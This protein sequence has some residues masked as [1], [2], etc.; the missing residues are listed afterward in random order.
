MKV[1]M[2]VF[3]LLNRLLRISGELQ[4]Y[5]SLPE[6]YWV[7]RGENVIGKDIATGNSVAV[8]SRQAETYLAVASAILERSVTRVADLGCNVAVLADF[9]QEGTEYDGCEYNP[10]ALRVAQSRTAMKRIQKRRFVCANI[11]ALPFASGSY[12]CVVIKDVLEHMEDFR[13]FLAEAARVSYRYVIV[14]NFIPWTEGRT[15]IRR[16]PGGYYHNLYNRQEVIS[17]ARTQ[18]LEVEE[19]ISALE[20]D[21]RPNEV[22]VFRKYESVEKVSDRSYS[23]RKMGQ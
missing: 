10:F 2:K 12:E 4:G 17:F 3:G 9:L 23:C 1:W 15:I 6:A 22:V 5:N 18:G 13:P 19:V 21:A 8:Q 16:E 14:A 11:R 20:Q 7:S